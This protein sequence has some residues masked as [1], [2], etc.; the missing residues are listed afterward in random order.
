[1]LAQHLSTDAAGL[2][3]FR[4]HLEHGPFTDMVSSAAVI[5]AMTL[6]QN[7]AVLFGWELD[8]GA[9]GEL[10]AES[11]ELNEESANP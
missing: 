1:M 6:L 8:G 2:T 9:I 5:A 4:T 7:A 3:S 10:L 11:R